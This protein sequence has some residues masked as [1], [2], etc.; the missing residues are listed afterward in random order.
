MNNFSS[1]KAIYHFGPKNEPIGTV[2]LGEKF[3][4]ETMDCY[5]GQISS[6]QVLRPD[7]DVSILN[8]STGPISIDSIKKGDTIKVTI[9]DIKVDEYGVMVTSVGLG[10][11]GENITEPNTKKIRISDGKVYFNNIV[12]KSEPMIGVIGVAT[13]EEETPCAVPGDHGANMDNK[14]IK[15]GSHIYLP[16]FVDGAKL[17]VGDLHGAMRDGELSGTGIEIGGVTTLEVNKS[18]LKVKMPIV[19]NDKGYFIV[20]SEQN[21]DLAI[22]KG[23]RYVTELLMKA[24]DIN[25]PDAYRLMSI[26]CDVQICQIVNSKKTI[27]IKV[28]KELIGCLF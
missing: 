19:E 22:K 10:P 5:S 13:E 28:P 15:K 3:T 8:A 26:T 25:F 9:H 18:K 2:K 17:A 21:L 27:R 1:D 6:E 12:V 7:I 4:V 11:L 14:E 23:I 16:V 24:K 20:A